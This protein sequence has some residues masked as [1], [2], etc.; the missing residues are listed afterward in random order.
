MDEYD[1]LAR[2]ENDV[3]RA[4]KLGDVEPVAIAKRMG[5]S[6]HNK[7]WGRVLAP[8]PRHERRSLSPSEAVSHAGRKLLSQVAFANNQLI[9]D[10]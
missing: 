5:Q 3:R 1:L 4:G 6:P 9:V 7:F 2:D 10:Q 8:N